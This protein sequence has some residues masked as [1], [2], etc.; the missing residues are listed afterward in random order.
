[1][2]QIIKGMDLMYIYDEHRNKILL[3]YTNNTKSQNNEQNQNN[4]QVHPCIQEEE[5]VL[6]E[7]ICFYLE[8]RHIEESLD[9]FNTSIR[10]TLKE[11]ENSPPPSTPEEKAYIGNNMN[12]HINKMRKLLTKL[13]HLSIVLNINPLNPIGTF[14]TDLDNKHNGENTLEIYQELVQKMDSKFVQDVITTTENLKS[15]KNIYGFHM[16]I[17]TITDEEKKYLTLEESNKIIDIVNTLY[18]ELFAHEESL[19]SSEYEDNGIFKVFKE[20]KSEELLR[21]RILISGLY[22]LDDIAYEKLR[23]DMGFAHRSFGTFSTIEYYKM[24]DKYKSDPNEW[25]Q[26]RKNHFQLTQNDPVLKLFKYLMRFRKPEKVGEQTSL[27]QN[28]MQEIRL[29]S[30]GQL[31]RERFDL[32][33]HSIADKSTEE[34][35]VTFNQRFNHVHLNNATSDYLLLSAIC[36]PDLDKVARKNHMLYVADKVAT[37][38]SV[39]QKHKLLD[40][41]YPKDKSTEGLSWWGAAYKMV[42]DIIIRYPKDTDLSANIEDIFEDIPL[43]S[44]YDDFG[45]EIMGTSYKFTPPRWKHLNLPDDVRE[46]IC[47]TNAEVFLSNILQNG[48]VSFEQLNIQWNGKRYTKVE[49]LLEDA[50]HASN[51]NQDMN[52]PDIQLERKFYANCVKPVKDIEDIIR[53][54]EEHMETCIK[55]IDINPK[56]Y[57]Y[58]ESACVGAEDIEQCKKD[59][60]ISYLDARIEKEQGNFRE[61]KKFLIAN[62]I[63]Q[64]NECYSETYLHL[65]QRLVELRNQKNEIELDYCKQEAT[66]KKDG[67][68]VVDETKYKDCKES[69]SP[70]WLRPKVVQ[71]GPSYGAFWSCIGKKIKSIYITKEEYCAGNESDNY[72]NCLESFGKNIKCEQPDWSLLLPNY[73]NTF[74][75]KFNNWWDNEVQPLQKL[76][77][78]V[79]DWEMKSTLKTLRQENLAQDSIH[80][81]IEIPMPTNKTVT[82]KFELSQKYSYIFPE[83]ARVNTRSKVKNKARKPY[84]HVLNL[85]MY[86]PRGGFQNIHFEMTFWSDYI[87][88][89]AEM[90]NKNEGTAIDIPKLKTALKEFIETYDYA[91][92]RLQGRE[93]LGKW[94][95]QFLKDNPVEDLESPWK[96]CNAISNPTKL[97]ICDILGALGI[98]EGGISMINEISGL[99]LHQGESTKTNLWKDGATA[100]RAFLLDTF[101]REKPDGAEAQSNTASSKEANETE[102]LI[103]LTLFKLWNLHLEILQKI[104]M[105]HTELTE[106]QQMQY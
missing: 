83:L 33:F 1:M 74:E 77:A 99:N 41:M 8:V 15:Y 16:L 72:L 66:V 86:I 91:T 7:I 82:P 63:T 103:N 20:K 4:E 13:E 84:R 35:A 87:L 104:S 50:I 27:Q 45:M 17:L 69:L 14:L 93:G 105:F 94:E 64:N 21:G 68:S 40:T 42:K 9:N 3:Q 58:T 52:S 5:N 92:L 73:V 34:Q 2:D 100:D 67:E 29:F 47:G 75:F 43:F 57:N 89:L 36:G 71:T 46:K 24:V 39:K 30:R 26:I 78:D 18:E 101:S 88:Y 49:E 61:Q 25:K 44:R 12:N 79:A 22:L 98:Q 54:Q 28:I 10:T 53:I 96:D 59:F 85:D 32:E 51:G 65:S 90:K 38:G 95:A 31:G 81:F 76:F 62:D 106:D 6:K 11:L 23:R 97:K 80:Q 56:V 60:C 70:G 19:D 37:A 102:Q 48:L 55:N